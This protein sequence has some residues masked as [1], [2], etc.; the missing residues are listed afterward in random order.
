MYVCTNVDVPLQIIMSCSQ[1]ADVKKFSLLRT[2]KHDYKFPLKDSSRNLFLLCGYHWLSACSF[3]YLML[4]IS[5]THSKIVME[6]NRGIHFSN[7]PL[8]QSKATWL[9]NDKERFKSRS[10]W[11]IGKNMGIAGG[12][13][14]PY[15]DL[16]ISK[17]VLQKYIQV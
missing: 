6:N 15:S 7:S 4:N 9:V 14:L 2:Q 8:K 11:W 5:W 3:L 10:V 13:Q 12:G 17:H 1:E 16:I